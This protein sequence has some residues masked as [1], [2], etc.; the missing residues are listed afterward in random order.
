MGDEPKLVYYD[1]DG[2]RVPEGSVESVVQY[3]DDDP[4]RPDSPQKKA[5]RKA[6]TLTAA[7]APEPE[8]E[9]VDDTADDEAKAIEA[10]AATKARKSSANK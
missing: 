4:A 7:P 9:A 8:P 2:H 6:Q 10:P 5:E 1:K 3:L